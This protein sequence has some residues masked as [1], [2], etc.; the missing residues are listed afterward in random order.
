[1]RRRVIALVLLLCLPLTACG[2]GEDRRDQGLFQRTTGLEEET[3]LLTVDGREVAAWRYLYWLERCCEGMEEQYRSAGLTLDWTAPLEGGTLADYA[4]DQALSDTVLYATVE[5]WAERYGCALDEADRSALED[6]WADQA[7][8]H[9]GEEAYLQS[10]ADRGLDRER[11]EELGGVGRLYTKLYRLSLEE[12]SA[13]APTEEELESFAQDRGRITVDRLLF[14]AGEDRE[15][16]RG[17]AAEAFARL[18]TAEDLAATFE[19]LASGEDRLDHPTFTLGDGTLP[20][21]LEEAAQALETGQCSGI[22]ETEEGFSILLRRE[23]DR[24]GLEEDWFDSRLQDD[25]S[26][27]SVELTEDYAALDVE[28]FSTALAKVRRRGEERSDWES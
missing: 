16:A 22:L 28:A 12:G 15:A 10:L 18:N 26:T 20:S 24:Q 7:A 17:R 11:V 19:T 13:L 27:A 3:T 5:T 21:A 2:G 6:A 8:E 14:S 23:T 9:G 4:K 1:M 25:A